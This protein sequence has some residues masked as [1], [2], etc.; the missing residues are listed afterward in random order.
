MPDDSVAIVN[1]A[2]GLG[3]EKW[4][5]AYK[6]KA[7]IFLKRDEIALRLPLRPFKVENRKSYTRFR[8]VP[9]QRRRFPPRSWAR[10]RPLLRPIGSIPLVDPSKFWEGV[11]DAHTAM[12]TTTYW[13]VGKVPRHFRL[14]E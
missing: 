10:T 4:H 6:L 1:S 9:N 8:L 3:T 2:A 11:G 7:L 5:L 12:E 13:T 14:R